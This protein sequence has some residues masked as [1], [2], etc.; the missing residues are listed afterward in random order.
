MG[1]I[2]WP[3]CF[4]LLIIMGSFNFLGHFLGFVYIVGASNSTLVRKSVA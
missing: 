2:F 3:L 1:V 4:W